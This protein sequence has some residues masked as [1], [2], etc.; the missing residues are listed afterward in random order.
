MIL[1]QSWCWKTLH[2]QPQ[3]RESQERHPQILN[4]I[5]V[6]LIQKQIKPTKII[7]IMDLDIPLLCP[8]A[9]Q[10]IF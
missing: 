7:T 6:L 5:L 4:Y 8:R 9:S 10:I 1:L 2:N 3:G